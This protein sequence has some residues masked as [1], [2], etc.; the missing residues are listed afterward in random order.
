MNSSSIEE[1]IRK[2]GRFVYSNR[3][4]SMLPLIR[5]GKDVVVLV[6]PVFPLRKYDVPLFKPA[7]FDGRY[8]L[9]R[10]VKVKDGSYVIR[11]DNCISCEYGVKDEDIV[12]VLSAV[13]RGG[14]EISVSSFGYKAYSRFWCFIYPL[15]YVLKRFKGLLRRLFR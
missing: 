14:K 9:H 3:G 15:R 13:V 2:N 1:E 7:H 5:E 10:I 6:S 12:G 4:R 11:G 8:I